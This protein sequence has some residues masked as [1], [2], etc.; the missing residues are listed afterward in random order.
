MLSEYRFGL[1]LRR[2][3]GLAVGA[4]A[5]TMAACGGDDAAPT[6]PPGGTTT[7]TSPTAQAG[8]A[9]AG[10]AAA[11]APSAPKPSPSAGTGGVV[12]AP[13]ATGG[14]GGGAGM[15][16]ATPAAGSG[17]AP[18]AGAGGGGMEMMGTLGGK[19]MYTGE[20][21]K[22]MTI[23]K[24]NKCPMSM[25][26]NGM[27]DNKSPALEWSGGPAD[28]KSFAIVLFDT[29]YNVFHWAIWD[30]PPTTNS[31]PEGLA[32]GYELMTPMG[33]HQRAGAGSDDHAYF[34]PCSDAGASAG[35]YQ[36]RLY[37]LKTDKLPLME[38]STGPMIQT[39]VMDAML[40]M[41]VWE[42][43]PE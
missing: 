29:M 3:A 16:A 8:R 38:S 9:A 35:T 1:V 2:S 6:P 10:A 7:V 24:K 27:G 32:S 39:A 41:T 37:A 33:A 22:G 4:V 15:T 28:T 31:L 34:G 36:Y 5:L 30:I 40:E 12:S 21:T 18:A 19:L 13:P 25:L 42:G 26:G 17:G 14:M 11:G 43:K 23:P 20:F